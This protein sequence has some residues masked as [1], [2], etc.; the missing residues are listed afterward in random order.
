MP[1]PKTKLNAKDQAFLERLQQDYP[2]FR[3]CLNAKRFSYRYAEPVS[4]PTSSNTPAMISNTPATNSNTPTKSR[5]SKKPAKPTI[6]I[7]PPPTKFCPSGA[8]RARSCPF[9]A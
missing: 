1:R 3:F 9:K 6:F 5:K 7:G 4:N 8:P 2:E